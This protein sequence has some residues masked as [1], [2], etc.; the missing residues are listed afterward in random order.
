MNPTTHHEDAMT[1]TA[2]ISAESHA[3]LADE[4]HQGALDIG[5]TA[6]IRHQL[7]ETRE[8]DTQPMAM[9]VAVPRSFPFIMVGAI[10]AVGLAVAAL[11]YVIPWACWWF[12]E[13]RGGGL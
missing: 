12:F 8:H 7:E 5:R 2:T 6:Y 4:Q 3:K 10:A 9:N 1:D 11:S 13:W